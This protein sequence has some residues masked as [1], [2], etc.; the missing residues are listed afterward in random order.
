MSGLWEERV[1]RKNQRQ[2][3]QCDQ[4]DHAHR[5]PYHAG[6]CSKMRVC[7]VSIDRPF[8][9]AVSGKDQK[10]SQG[11]KGKAN[12]ISH[13]LGQ[14]VEIAGL[15][16]RHTVV[17][18]PA[19][20]FALA[21]GERCVDDERSVTAQMLNAKQGFSYSLKPRPINQRQ[22]CRFQFFHYLGFHRIGPRLQRRQQ[23]FRRSAAQLVHRYRPI[24]VRFVS[25][26]LGCLHEF[27][28]VH[29]RPLSPPFYQGATP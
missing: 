29:P 24:S 18:R 3:R 17:E 8:E 27:L 22:P 9:Q 23:R 13:G 25:G 4:Q 12:R 10:R 6:D 5:C 1:Q 28:V 26:H 15:E 2:E 7:I 21:T 16:Q 20:G 14:R 11:N 19:V